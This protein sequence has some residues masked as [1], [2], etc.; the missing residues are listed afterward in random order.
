MFMQVG[1]VHEA[2]A[3]TELAIRFD[4]TVPSSSTITHPTSFP[5]F[6]SCWV[7]RGV[8][9]RKLVQSGPSL[10]LPLYIH[11][12]A[13]IVAQDSAR[14]ADGPVRTESASFQLQS[15]FQHGGTGCL[16]LFHSRHRQ[17]RGG[18]RCPPVVHKAGCGGRA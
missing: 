16:F 17:C 11:A 8:A 12:K 18:L 2:A 6:P 13:R 3:P 15:R 1:H 9:C 14:P 4:A 7:S 5:N 10:W